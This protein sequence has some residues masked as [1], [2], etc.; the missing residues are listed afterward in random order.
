MYRELLLGCGYRRERLLDPHAYPSPN[1]GPFAPQELRWKNVLKIDANRDC[2]PDFV[3]DIQAGLETHEDPPRLHWSSGLFRHRYASNWVLLDNSFAEAHAY[4]VL[5][6]LGRQGD[7]LSFFKVFDEIWR[8][9]VPGG[10]LC[11][12]V[13]SRF[14]PWLWGDPGH[15]RAIL[16]ETLLFLDRTHYQRQIG[17]NPSSD[18]RSYFVGDW[19]IVYSRDNEERHEFVLQ[20]VK[21]IRDPAGGPRHD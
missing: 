2:Q 15:C 3:M 5:E 9:L 10:W 14:S 20:A 4:E 1:S 17:R 8:V 6:H 21:P 7:L 16:P 11:A 18:Y 12:T 19:D 13:P